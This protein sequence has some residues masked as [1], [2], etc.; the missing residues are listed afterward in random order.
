MFWFKDGEL[1]Q[2]AKTAAT[3]GLKRAEVV[4][5]AHASALDLLEKDLQEFIKQFT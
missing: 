3:N 4:G 1:L 5:D 2:K